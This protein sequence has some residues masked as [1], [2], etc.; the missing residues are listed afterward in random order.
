MHAMLTSILFQ[1]FLLVYSVDNADAFNR[2]D[3]TKTFLEKAM[4][5]RKEPVPLVVL[6][7]KIDQPTRVVEREFAVNWAQREKGT[8]SKFF[9]FQVRNLG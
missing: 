1:A 4:K 7:N 3:L 8:F 6:A 5:E 2:M 9:I